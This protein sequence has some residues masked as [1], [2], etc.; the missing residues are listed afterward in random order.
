[1]GTW[2]FTFCSDDPNYGGYCQPIRASS[3]GAARK[4]MFEMY[5]SKWAFQYSEEEWL[6]NKNDPSR[7][8]PMERELDLVVVEDSEN[9]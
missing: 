2:Y 5:G 8:Y 7:W 6:K 4:K 3:W 1:M 9:G